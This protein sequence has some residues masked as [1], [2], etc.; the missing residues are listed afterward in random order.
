MNARADDR[1]LIADLVVTYSNAVDERDWTTFESLFA[2]D[3]RIDYRSSGGIAGTPSEITA[4]M[5]DAMAMFTWTLHSISTHR[6]VFTGDQEAAGSL[7]LLARHALTW[8]GVEEVMDVNAIYRDSYTRTGA[9]WRFA[10][11]L[12]ETLLV[13][14]GRFAEMVAAG[15]R[16]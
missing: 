11:R 4:W 14:G 3:A 2:A 13:T 10:S 16:D 8:K 1:A 6:V 15:I 7:H 12:E 9:G 5:P